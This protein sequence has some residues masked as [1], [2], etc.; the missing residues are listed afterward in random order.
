MDNRKL[1]LMAQDIAE[2]PGERKVHFLNPN[3]VR[4]NKSL[5]DAIGLQHMGVHLIQ[6]EP[7]RESTEYHI[8][9]EEEEAVYVLSGKGILVIEAENFA[10]RPGDFFGFP[11]HR[12]AHTILND[13]TETLECR[14]IGQRLDQDVADYPNQHK[15]LYRNNGEWNLVDMADIRV[16]RESTQ[17]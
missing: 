4:I 8:H 7:G 12:A 2:M 9:H 10:I 14:D 16:L 11:R 17:E 1:L 5:G 6:V 13:G 15:R 3:A